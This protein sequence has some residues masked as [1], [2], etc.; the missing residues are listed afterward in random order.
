M[1]RLLQKY[2]Q[3]SFIYF[4]FFPKIHLGT[5]PPR[6]LFPPH[7]T[8]KPQRSGL[9]W[10][11]HW[12]RPTFARVFTFLFGISFSLLA[13]IYIFLSLFQRSWVVTLRLKRK[14]ILIEDD[15]KTSRASHAGKSDAVCDEI[16]G[17]FGSIG[18]GCNIGFSLILLERKGTCFLLMIIFGHFGKNMFVNKRRMCCFWMT[19]CIRT[20]QDALVWPRSQWCIVDKSKTLWW[21]Y[22][23]EFSLFLWHFRDLRA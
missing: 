6:W 13:F 23:K 20:S 12:R 14:V 3:F 21:R 5:L 17:S 2:R 8:E 1:C 11:S 19:G 10:L 22:R 9:D 4:F 15:N 16:R 18:M 7:F